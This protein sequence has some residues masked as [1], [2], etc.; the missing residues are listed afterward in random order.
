M[1]YFDYMGCV[2]ST[3][4]YYYITGF[5]YI[6]IVDTAQQRDSASDA[7]TIMHHVPVSNSREWH[8]P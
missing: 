4:Q 3:L 5:F 8:L 2:S 6:T 1:S 7:L